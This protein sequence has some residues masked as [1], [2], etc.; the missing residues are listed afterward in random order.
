MTQDLILSLAALAALVPVAV[1]IFRQAEAVEGR[2]FWPLLVVALAGPA[3]YAVVSLGGT[4]DGR[5]SAALWVTIAVTLLL[6]VL[7]ALMFGEARRLAPLLLPYL[8][9]LGLLATIWTQAPA[10]ATADPALPD[11]WLAVH[12]AVS[13]TT[14]GLATLAAIAGFAVV[15]QERALKSKHSSALTRRLPSIADGEA[16]E[17]G[18]LSLSEAVLGLGLLTGIALQYLTS[19]QVLVLDHKTL[20]SLLAFAVIGVLLLLHYRTGLRGRQA[21]RLVLIGYCLL[22]LAYIG[23]KFVTDVVIA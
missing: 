21:A 19:G 16:L 22:T 8:L 20:L 18:L 17:V 11:A 9:G 5:F 4:W 2:L 12:I 6:F 13:V 1:I 14:Y 15:L 3:C 10:A 7:A 23:V